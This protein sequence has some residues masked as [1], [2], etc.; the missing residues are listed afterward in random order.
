MEISGEMMEAYCKNKISVF[1][2]KPT[3]I[4]GLM[5]AFDGCHGVFHTS[6][7]ADPAGISGYSVSFHFS[8]YQLSYSKKIKNQ[9]PPHISPFYHVEGNFIQDQINVFLRMLKIFYVIFVHQVK[10]K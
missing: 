7:F 3:E 4:Q 1:M 5:V 8:E 6:A 9:F 10:K 2:A